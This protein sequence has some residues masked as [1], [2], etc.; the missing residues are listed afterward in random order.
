M[1]LEDKPRLI[2]YVR[3]AI[4]WRGYHQHEQG[5]L[6]RNISETFARLE[7]EHPELTQ[8]IDEKLDD[9][10]AFKG[11]REQ[12][13]L[14][15]VIDSVVGEGRIR[16]N[17]TKTEP[18]GSSDF[19]GC[20]DDNPSVAVERAESIEIL[21][22]ALESELDA[23]PATEKLMLKEVFWE[24]KKQADIAREFGMPP[25]TANDAFRRGIKV[26]A[27]RLSHLRDLRT[28]AR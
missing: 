3:R 21:R 12:S 28:P 9:R 8:R 20:D 18:L 17:R 4:G 5:E 11:S 26:L 25:T 6:V 1:P 16:R 2:R 15:M 22:G 24:G 14:L 19:A 10:I 23:L 13:V 27:A 7:T